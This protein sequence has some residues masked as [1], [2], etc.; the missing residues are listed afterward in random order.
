MKR[1]FSTV[2]FF[3]LVALSAIALRPVRADDAQSDK[4]LEV[5]KALDA[6]LDG[7]WL[8]AD[9]AKKATDEMVEKFKAAGDSIEDVERLLRMGRV[10]Y[11][12]QKTTGKMLQMELKSKDGKVAKKLQFPLL[13]LQCEN[14]D[15]KTTFIIYVPKSYKPTKPTPLLVVGHGGNSAMS[16]QYAVQATIG[17]IL[18]WLPVVEKKGMILVAPQSERGWGSIGNSII[19]S[20]ISWAQR[21]FNIDPDRIYITGHSMG[22]HLS[23]RSAIYLP[24]RWGA[25]SPMSGGYDYVDEKLTKAARAMV[26]VP[27]YAT[28]GSHEPYNINEYNHKMDKWAKENHH[29]WI[30]VEKQGGHEIYKDELPKVAAFMLAHPRNLYRDRTYGYATTSVV[31]DSTEKNP[32]WSQQH[33]WNPDRPIDHSTFHWLRMYPLPQDTPQDKR[34]QRVWARYKGDNHFDLIAENARKVRIYLHPKM[35]DFSKPIVVTAN[36]ETVFDA[37]VEPDM[38]TMLELVREFDDRGRIFYAGIEVNISTDAKDFPE[39]Q[40]EGLKTAG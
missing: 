40:G 11:G 8:P 21:E 39:P 33:T 38:R 29:D 16:A 9:E 31:F 3:T 1:S 27:G 19:F 32:R 7:R 15:Y 18:D 36:G 34:E 25:V 4:Q 24:D 10:K 23:Y 37:K 20:L 14:V 2:L 28:Y 17:G 22:G 6:Y 30:R 26:D 13:D 12:G 35:V 5:R